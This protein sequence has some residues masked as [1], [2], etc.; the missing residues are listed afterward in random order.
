MDGAVTSFDQFCL[1][2]MIW[3]RMQNILPKY[4]KSRKAGRPLKDLRGAGT[5]IGREFV[6]SNSWRIFPVCSLL[7][8]HFGEFPRSRKDES[9][10]KQSKNFG[11]A[12]RPKCLQKSRNSGG[13]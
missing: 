5:L 12:S 13:F 6:Y 3:E 9:C 11:P 8:R 1:P 10:Q 2:D 4:R 7:S